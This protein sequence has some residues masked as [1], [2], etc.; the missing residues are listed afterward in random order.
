[1]G[2]NPGSADVYMSL[3]GQDPFCVTVLYTSGSVVK[4]VASP[5]LH[6]PADITT[7]EKERGVSGPDPIS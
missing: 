7:I 5:S 1:M 3:E 6:R 2:Q 4:W